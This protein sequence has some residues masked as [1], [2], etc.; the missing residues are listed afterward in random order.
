MSLASDVKKIVSIN[1]RIKALE[2][3]R[4]GIYKMYEM[5]GQGAVDLLNREHEALLEK[6]LQK[7]AEGV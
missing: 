2:S 4:N 6:Q 1:K 3:E 5:V 7:Q